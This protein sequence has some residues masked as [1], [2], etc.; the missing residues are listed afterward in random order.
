[1]PLL[2]HLGNPILSR[3]RPV[4]RPKNKYPKARVSSKQTEIARRNL[5]P[6]THVNLTL[7][8]KHNISGH[9]YG[10]GPVTVPL[11]V[12]QVLQEGERN[13]ARTDRNFAS[14]KAC[15]IGPGRIKGGLSVSEVAPEYFDMQAQNAVPFGV[16]DRNSGLFTAY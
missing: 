16:V 5:A 7:N 1:M 14:P 3:P 2:D 9:F 13:A 15:V 4:R 11:D 12:A 8:A 6:A 10:P